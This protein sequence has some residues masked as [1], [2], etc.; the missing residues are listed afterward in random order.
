MQPGTCQKREEI[1]SQGCA[2]GPCCFVLPPCAAN[3]N[4]GLY[5]YLEFVPC[6]ARVVR[7]WQRERLPS[8]QSRDGR[9]AERGG[10]LGAKTLQ[11][12]E[13][14]Q[15]PV[16]GHPLDGL[17]GPLSAVPSPIGGGRAVPVT[18]RL[19]WSRLDTHARMSD[20]PPG[21]RSQLMRRLAISATD[22]ILLELTS[23]LVLPLRRIFNSLECGHR[24][25]HGGC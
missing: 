17:D 8:G 20:A 25:D 4:R 24:G 22:L 15:M 10:A 16:D 7:F 14:N 19:R 5:K 9:M 12:D 6:T 3:R 21:L 18:C 13:V 11:M 1:R 2:R 23:T